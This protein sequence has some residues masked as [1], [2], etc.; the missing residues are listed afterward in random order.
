LVLDAAGE[1]ALHQ[2]AERAALQFA[3][4]FWAGRKAIARQLSAEPGVK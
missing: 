4:D 3:A 1:V 2:W